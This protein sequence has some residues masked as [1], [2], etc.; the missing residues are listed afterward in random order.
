MFIYMSNFPMLIACKGTSRPVCM[1]FVMLE[2]WGKE[3]KKV[4]SVRRS[5]SA[6]YDRTANAPPNVIYA[7]RRYLETKRTSPCRGASG[8]A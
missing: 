8:Y 4:R 1:F 2:W 5:A 3:K 6:A 7:W